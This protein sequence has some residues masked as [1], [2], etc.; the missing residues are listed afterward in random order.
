MIGELVL[1]TVTKEGTPMIR[2][3][4]GDITRIIDEPC[5]C[6]CTFHRLSRIT[7]RT[8][9][10]IIIHGTK[11]LVSQ[12]ESILAEVEHAQPH[13]QIILKREGGMEEMEILLEVSE[14]YFS[15]EVRGMMQIQSQIQE[16]IATE[17]GLHCH[18]KL[19]EPKTLER[20]G[21]KVKRV[22]D[23]RGQ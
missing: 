10:Q 17:F 11:I 15:D 5:P 4:T 14:S 8:D 16:R 19:V 20:P 9:D 22:L 7:Q 2:F 1:T 23:M 12:I 3:R 13:F 21:E 6:G 18:V